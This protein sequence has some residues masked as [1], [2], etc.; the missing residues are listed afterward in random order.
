MRRNL[1]KARK[2]TF[3]KDKNTYLHIVNSTS[4]KIQIE[5]K[6]DEQGILLW[7]YHFTSKNGV[8]RTY[9]ILKV[10]LF[11]VLAKKLNGNST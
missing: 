10:F 3:K 2:I 9:Y 8:H 7:T 6:K 11:A 4:N 1:E 5:E